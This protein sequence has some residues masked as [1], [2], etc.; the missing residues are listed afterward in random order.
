MPPDGA[1]TLSDIRGP[2]MSIVCER[3]GRRETYS[4]ARLMERHRDAS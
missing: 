1:L 2:T 4:V 3:C